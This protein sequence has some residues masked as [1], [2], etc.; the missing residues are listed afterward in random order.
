MIR[1]L[2]ALTFFAALSAQAG[3][4]PDPHAILADYAKIASDHGID[5]A[6]AVEIG[7]IQQWITVR[8]RDRDAPILLLIHGGPAAPELPN[9]Y[10][11]EPAWDDY[12]TVVEWDQRGS[13]KTFELNDP[14]KIGPTIT[15]ER[16]I[17]DAIELVDYLRKTYHRDKIFVMGHSWGSLVGLTVAQRK[18][19]WLYAYIGAGQIINMKKAEKLS[20]D[21]TLAQA[22][23]AGNETA[24][25]E[26]TAIA[27][28]PE[29]DGSLPLDKLGTE[30]KWS[31]VYGALIHGRSSYDPLEN[32]EKI[33]PDYSE[34]DF[35]AIDQGSQLSLPRL[36]TDL[37]DA[38]FT[39]LDKLDCPL[40][41]F[42][43]RTDYTTPSPLMES[44]FAKLKAPKK[45]FVWFEQSSHMM[46]EE[47][48][49]RVLI[50]LVEDVLPLA[51][52]D[53]SA[54]R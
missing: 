3:G 28:Y 50:H 18:P 31:I 36:I 6:K 25:Q 52:S 39:K 48:P 13:G 24:V 11:F 27:P 46:F 14:E 49:G 43:G 5:E 21:W 40:I 9:R 16:M 53:A 33:S 17:E 41:F 37:V 23:K 20:Y 22:K 15:K 8:G 19:E 29:A 35:K 4:P 32:T 30:R 34:A 26:L 51:K 10:L 54:S 44:W 38:D 12:F 2:A 1:L 45:K 7:G 42:A 47:E